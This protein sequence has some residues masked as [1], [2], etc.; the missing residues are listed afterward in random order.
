MTKAKP[1]KPAKPAK[2]AK[3]K[4]PAVVISSPAKVLY[5]ED[6][7]TKQQVVDY[8][9]AVMPRLLPEIANRPLSV[10]RCPAGIGKQCFFQKHHTPGLELVDLVPLKEEGGHSANYLVANSA[11]AVMELVQFNALE[12]HPW[13]AHADQPDRA[14][15]IVFDLD[16]GEGVPWAEVKRAALQVRDLLKQLG[17]RS[18][19]RSTGG[20]G[21]HV[22][23]PLAPACE[24]EVVRRFARSFAEAMAGSEPR[25]F[26]ASATLKLRPGRIYVDYLRNGRGATA[27]ASYSLR[28]RA[29][30]PVALPLAWSELAGLRR[31][32]AFTLKNV[33]AL[34]KGRRDPWAGIGRVRQDLSRWRD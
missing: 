34:L 33:P 16:P 10:V 20:K 9:A 5:P 12:F 15:R 13:G 21:L 32:D 27:V 2:S 6:G 18:Y 11:E 28:A 4:A 7:I 1:A 17:F 24:W 26:V 19:L 3:A 8:Y 14:D 31:G 22:L 30:A 29:G 23:M 25:R